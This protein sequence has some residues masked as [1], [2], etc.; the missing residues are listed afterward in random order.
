MLSVV[1]KNFLATKVA[2][3]KFEFS[4]DKSV[5]SVG[6]FS[7]GLTKRAMQ[8]SENCIFHVIILLS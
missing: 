3:L 6:S 5:S 1:T 8:F 2:V 7:V 4:V